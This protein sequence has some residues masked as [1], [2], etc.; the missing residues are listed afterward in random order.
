MYLLLRRSY[1]TMY[2]TS[3][4]AVADEPARRAA[5]RQT[6]KFKNSHVTMPSSL[7]LVICHPVARIDIATCVQNLTTLGSAVPVIDLE[8][9]KFLMDHMT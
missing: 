6:A 7:L 5:S 1:T 4:S 8:P 2:I 9:P 3:S